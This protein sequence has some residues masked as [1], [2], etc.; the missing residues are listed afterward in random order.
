MFPVQHIMMGGHQEELDTVQMS[1]WD[2]V[3]LHFL[4]A[5]LYYSQWRQALY[6]YNDTSTCAVIKVIKP[7][8]KS[9]L[10]R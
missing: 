2:Q 8:A 3:M 5:D 7:E 6:N 1:G 4:Y 9:H 10:H